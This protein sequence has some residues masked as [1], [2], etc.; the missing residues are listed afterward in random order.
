MQPRGT[1]IAG[2]ALALGLAA[3]VSAQYASPSPAKTGHE[4]HAAMGAGAAG[5]A[6]MTA[7]LVD[8]EAKAK[9]QSAVVEVM[10]KGVNLVDPAK[11]N[12][13]P[14][15]GEG[16]LHYQVDDG[17]IIATTAP[18]L[19]FHGLKQGSHTIVVALAANDHSPLGPQE[20]LTVSVP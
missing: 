1:I 2:A 6:T 12:E 20:K 13:K 19:S 14:A 15:K 9:K 10:V 3:A 7:K 11:V 5:S 18:K 17:P 4:G 8:S 16:H